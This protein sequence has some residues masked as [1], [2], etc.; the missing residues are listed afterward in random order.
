M[1]L[2]AI[3]VGH[4]AHHTLSLRITKRLD[5]TQI[6]HQSELIESTLKERRKGRGERGKEKV[7]R[8][9]LFSVLCSLWKF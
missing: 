7:E 3:R 9:N 4:V 8:R 1:A 6:C 2:F 5:R